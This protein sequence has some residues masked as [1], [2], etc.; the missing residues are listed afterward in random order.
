MLLGVQDR[1]RNFGC[2]P[3]LLTATVV[4]HLLLWTEIILVF[5]NGQVGPSSSL[6]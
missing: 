4:V 6:G 3:I 5:S 2:H 1:I